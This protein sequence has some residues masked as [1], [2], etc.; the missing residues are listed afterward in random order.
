M[1][2]PRESFDEWLRG[3]SCASACKPWQCEPCTV[4]FI[5]A[6]RR[7]LEEQPPASIADLRRELENYRTANE[8]LR[9]ELL[10]T[11][12]HLAAHVAAMHA[13]TSS[14]LQSAQA[15]ASFHVQDVARLRNEIDLM[16]QELELSRKR[17]R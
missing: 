13:A 4:A 10:V 6:M 2:T 15:Q 17:G 12:A 11:K 1:R 5:G 9:V 14:L 3:C 8:A 16:R 7:S